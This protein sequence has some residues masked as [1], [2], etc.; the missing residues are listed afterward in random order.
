ME[1]SHFLE[2]ECIVILLSFTQLK[3]KPGSCDYADQNFLTV[4]LHVE[5]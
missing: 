5:E 4:P 1:L 3:H 2:A